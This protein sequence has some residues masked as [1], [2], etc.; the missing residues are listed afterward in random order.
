MSAELGRPAWAERHD[1]EEATVRWS[2]SLEV[3][4]EPDLVDEESPAITV[5]AYL[6]DHIRVDDSGTVRVERDPA[7]E[8]L[9]GNHML[10]V[11]QWAV[12]YGH[13][14]EDP[15]AVLIRPR[16]INERL[17][18]PLGDA[19][20]AH[21]MASAEQPVNVWIA[22]GAFCGLR[23]ME[24]A[25]LAREDV[26][27]GVDAPFLRVI[28]KGGTERGRA[29]ARSRARPAR[30]LRDAAPRPPVHAHGRSTRP[31]LTDAGVR[32]DQRPPARLRRHRHRP[33]VAAP[34]RDETV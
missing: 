17:P 6:Y 9:V 24:I 32:T 33:P 27:D 31:T 19:A 16:H 30:G 34:V 7:P 14:A 20:I 11:A 22:L 28:G 23:C 12:L 2:R 29:A 4:V 8:L 3:A 25:S 13:R 21:A 26:I 10:T 18:R 15:S 1:E 5:E